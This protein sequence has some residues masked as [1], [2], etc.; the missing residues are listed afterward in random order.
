[1]NEA[2][3][4]ARVTTK[5]PRKDDPSI[6]DIKK[7]SYYEKLNSI[8]C[9]VQKSIKTSKASLAADVMACLRE[10]TSG[11]TTELTIQIVT[12]KIT[13]EPER[14]V[15]TWTTEKEYFGR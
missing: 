15:K 12:N 14:I 9:Q 3:K 1:M 2:L 6:V 7:E 13:H 5:L 4:H 11:D 8:E 10:I